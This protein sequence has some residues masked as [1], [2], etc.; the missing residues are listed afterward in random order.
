[1]WK[2]PAAGFVSVLLKEPEGLSVGKVKLDDGRLVLGL[3][4]EP[5]LESSVVQVYGCA[6]R[7]IIF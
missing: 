2:V 5:E 4:G 7:M 6:E 3:I 1:M